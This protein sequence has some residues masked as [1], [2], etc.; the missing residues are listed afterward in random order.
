MGE[1]PKVAL[2]ETLEAKIKE[3]L[4]KINQKAPVEEG[5]SVIGE[6]ERKR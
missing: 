1:I 2:E 3:R 4:I 6:E 5:V